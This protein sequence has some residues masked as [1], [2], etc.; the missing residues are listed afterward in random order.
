[1]MPLYHTIK[2]YDDVP[3]RDTALDGET[4]GQRDGLICHSNIALYVHCMLTRDKNKLF[5]VSSS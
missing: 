2:K 3:I 4:D 5:V 1:M